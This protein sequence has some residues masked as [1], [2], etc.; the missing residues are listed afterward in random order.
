MDVLDAVRQL[1][2]TN[3]DYWTADGLPA[4]SAVSMV[5]GRNV[6]R[7][8]INLAAPGITRMKLSEDPNA[9]PTAPA[10]APEESAAPE[11]APADAPVATTD[12]LTAAREVLAAEELK[13]HE[14]KAAADA[15]AAAAVAQ[16]RRVSAATATVRRATTPQA[17]QSAVIDYLRS[18][19]EQRAARA[20]LAHELRESGITPEVAAMAQFA[21]SKIDRVMSARRARPSDTRKPPR[22]LKSGE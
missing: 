7:R 3:D 5:M 18:E 20:K 22:L 6:T 1:D 16:A 17:S 8:D 10:S 21:G 13:L 4:T 2:I 14:L 15:A 19:R 12:E 11:P 9:A